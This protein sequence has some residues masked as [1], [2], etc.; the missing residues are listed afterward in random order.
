MS[1]NIEMNYKISDGYE[2][3]YPNILL[4]NV[5]DWSASIYSK[6]EIDSKI[7]T[8][9]DSIT[10]A[11]MNPGGWNV[12]G[13]FNLGT[14]RVVNSEKV[15]VGESFV[16][17][18][19]ALSIQNEYWFSYQGQANFLVNGSN[20]ESL[21]F[22][23]DLKS[24]NE[25]ELENDT[26]Y[27]ESGNYSTLN[28]NSAFSIRPARKDGK[29]I[30]QLSTGKVGAYYDGDQVDYLIMNNNA[31]LQIRGYYGSYVDSNTTL[32][33]LKNEISIYSRKINS[34]S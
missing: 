30:F 9:N 21:D 6:S 17:I 24:N 2:V 8:I 11:Q 28:L 12:I 5:T 15:V 22:T 25:F 33:V 29:I 31:S 34:I 27:S 10:N 18:P 7:S 26:T 4:A 20:S 19:I 32:N 14:G 1:K 16:N 3:L 23:L 13:T